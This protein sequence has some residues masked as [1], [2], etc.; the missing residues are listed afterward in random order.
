MYK[1]FSPILKYISG[2]LAQKGISLDIHLRI[3]PSYKEAIDAM[4]EGACD[5]ARFGPASYILAKRKNS[6]I[7]LLV[8][9][10]KHHKKTFNGVFITQKDSEINSIHDLKGKTLAFGDKHST[11]GRFLAQAELLKVGIRANDLKGFEFLGRHD[12]VALAVSAGD[13]DA[14]VV[15]ENTYAKYAEGY[16]LKDIDEFPNVTKPWIVRENFDPVLFAAL[17]EVLLDLK[18]R[19]V[20]KELKQDG[21]MP[22]SDEDYNFVRQGMELSKIFEGGM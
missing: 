6:K 9:E 5:F 15:K 4:A 13:Y 7:K 19:N 18:D 8:M 10:Q 22:A 20:L 3:Y 1:K 17:R 2:R 11:I 14:G 12:R 21:F 16:K